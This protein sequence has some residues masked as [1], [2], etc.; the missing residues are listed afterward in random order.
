LGLAVLAI[1]A[2]WSSQV[3]AA[4]D[5]LNLATVS[6]TN[7]ITPKLTSRY[8]CY[9]DGTDIA[10]NS[11]SLYVTTGGLVGMGTATPTYR[12][13]LG[14]GTGT[15]FALYDGG[16]EA[17]SVGFGIQSDLLEF[18]G[19]TSDTDYTFGY[20]TS[21]SLTRLLTIEGTG[22]VGIGTTAP[23]TTLHINSSSVIRLS[24]P[25]APGGYYTDLVEQYD[26]TD[27][28]CIYNAQVGRI[29]GA[30]IF[31]GLSG[32]GGGQASYVSGYYGLGFA[33]A[34]RTPAPAI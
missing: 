1:A 9:T 25:S 14:T 34:R 4:D 13:S 31:S 11:P 23:S 20:G 16:S 32:F 24:H 7:A 28:F 17:T 5:W 30:K 22:S 18:K 8:V 15:R 10:C 27:P 19:A 21:G 2:A 33:L 3:L 26:S 6:M 29:V 12:L